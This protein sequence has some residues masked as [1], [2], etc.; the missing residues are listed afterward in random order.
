M[1]R[2][3]KQKVGVAAVVERCTV[4]SNSQCYHQAQRLVG[5]SLRRPAVPGDAIV[6]L[7]KT[8][9]SGSL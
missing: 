9:E 1:C 3:L 4:L 8:I 6:L 5:V 2:D 7:P